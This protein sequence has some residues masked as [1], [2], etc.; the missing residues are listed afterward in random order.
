MHTHINNIRRFLDK[1]WRKHGHFVSAMLCGML[2]GALFST[3]VDLY[4]AA[5]EREPEPVR[6]ESA[7]PLTLVPRGSKTESFRFVVSLHSHTFPSLRSFVSVPYV[8]TSETPVTLRS[9]ASSSVS[10]AWLQSRAQTVRPERTPMRRSSSASSV[11]AVATVTPA[12]SLS[13]SS[14]VSVAVEE[15]AEVSSDD[16]PAFE[17]TV[18]PISKVPNWGAMRTPAEW[19]RSYAAMTAE[20]FVS[21]PSYDAAVQTKPMN[22]LLSPLTD[23]NIPLITAK[24]FYSTDYMGSYDLDAGEH[25]GDHPGVDLKLALGT[26]IGAI[27]GGRVYA[28]KSNAVLGTYVVIEHRIDGAQF[29][30]VYGHLGSASVTAGTAVKPGTTIGFAGNSGRSVSPHLHLEVNKGFL[31]DSWVN[32]HGAAGAGEGSVHPLAFIRT[33]GKI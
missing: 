28:I 27:A 4:Q 12:S 15:A 13:S 5:P 7:E 9:S 2:F 31:P 18:W 16:F 6:M 20:D 11:S 3:Y 23:E 21:I 33:G 8:V 29:F 25:S 19:D 17:R 26:P 22:S 14:S 1:A 24:L 10:S 30:S 32:L